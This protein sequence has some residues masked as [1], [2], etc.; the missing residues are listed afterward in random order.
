VRRRFRAVSSSG[1]PCARRGPSPSPESS[2]RPEPQAVG[3]RAN[4]NAEGQSRRVRRGPV[5]GTGGDGHSQCPAAAAGWP[6]TEPITVLTAGSNGNAGWP[7]PTH[8]RG[9]SR[10]PRSPV[11]APA[12]IPACTDTGSDAPPGSRHRHTER[13]AVPACR[14]GKEPGTPHRSSRS[15][16]SRVSRRDRGRGCGSPASEIVSARSSCLRPETSATTTRSSSFPEG[17]LS[18]P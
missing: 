17:F 2:H 4:R 15:C 5:G 3:A 8:S 13:R 9:M 6:W 1:L 12:P 7:W 16:D 18:S 11:A 14:G 10:L